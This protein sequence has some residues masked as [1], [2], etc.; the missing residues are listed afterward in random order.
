[1]KTTLAPGGALLLLGLLAACGP[2]PQVPE[3]PMP[4]AGPL[5]TA[6]ATALPPPPIVPGPCDAAQAAAMTA[7]FAARAAGE[8]PRMQ[9][10]GAMTCAVTLDGQSTTSAMFP[11]QQGYCYTF[12][13][14]ALLPQPP[15]GQAPPAPPAWGPPTTPIA[16][17]EMELNADLAGGMALPPAFATMAQRPLLVDTERGERASMAAK[18]A[19]YQWMWPIP[20]QVRLIL[21]PKGGSGPVAAQVYRRKL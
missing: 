8:A 11:V 13:G 7:A 2:Q 1:M 18:Q 10:E 9:P 19:C 14:Q 15:A 12:L 6:S 3:T 17:L 20:G 21:R 5:P 16:D 4:D